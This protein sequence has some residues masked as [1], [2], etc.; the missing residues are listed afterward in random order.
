MPGENLASDG[1]ELGHAA[2]GFPF[3]AVLITVYGYKTRLAGLAT[4]VCTCMA[5][6]VHVGAM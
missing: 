3:G 2:T 1:V 5:V 6:N 4:V